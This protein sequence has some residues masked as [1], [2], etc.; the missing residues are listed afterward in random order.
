MKERYDSQF[1]VEIEGPL[2]RGV[3]H[4]SLQQ[5]TETLTNTDP[6]IYKYLGNEGC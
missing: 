2:T 1:E 5:R 4:M 6:I 3:S